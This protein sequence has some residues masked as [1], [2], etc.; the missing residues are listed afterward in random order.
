[1]IGE[2]EE[3]KLSPSLS[4]DMWDR[5]LKRTGF[6]GVETEVHDCESEEFY[7]FSVIKSTASSSTP[8]NYDSEIVL[9]TG[10]TS[11]S[12]SWL[13]EL[14]GSI[15][16]AIGITPKIESLETVD[17]E[18]KVCIFLGDLQQKSS[19]RDPNFTEFEAIKSLCTKSKGLLWATCGGAVDCQNPDASLS[20]GFLRT[21]RVEYAGKRMIALDLDPK[22]EFWSSRTVSALT[23]VVEKLF[24][25]SKDN[26]IMDFELADRDGVI[27]VPRYY[28]DTERNKV[29]FADPA[30]QAMVQL[31]PFCQ[32]DRPF[33]LTVGTPGLLDTLAFNDDPDASKELRHDSVEIEPQAFGVNFRDVMVA[34][35][36]LDADYMGFECSGIVKRVG[37][38]AAAEGLK[39][40]DRVAALM[41][42]HYGNL[43]RV[44]WTSAVH[45]PDDMTFEIAATLPMCY[46]TAYFS[47]HHLGR[48]QKGD[49]VLIHAGT[50]GV[51]QAAIVLAKHAGA[52]IFVTVGTEKK[53]EFVMN[54]YG[55]QPDHIFSSRDASFAPGV[56]AMTQGKGV[57]IVLNTLAGPLLQ[58][59]FNCIARFGRF[60]EIGKRDLEL[61]SSL[62][63]GAFTRSVSF[64]SFDLLL[65]GEYQGAEV[66]RVLKEIIHLFRQNIITPVQPV[67]IFPLSDIEKTFRL[68]QAGK[69]M[70]KIVVSVKPDDLVPVSESNFNSQFEILG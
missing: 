47:L 34:M 65:F 55:I 42:G 48:V 6:G 8:S 32:D 29:V 24:D 58:E 22:S 1:L 36:Q 4:I 31:E 25:Y 70:G 26:V 19:L 16:K 56:L 43:V 37:S 20:Q 7:S 54:E 17:A 14:K 23:E 41:R 35:G 2:E 67:T 49:K 45:I 5:V 11:P 3:R 40:G 30:S 28:R 69:H 10:T 66:N 57:E 27:Q 59:S 53:R 62:E 52:E 63:M 13:E 68:M 44:D 15:S 51:G 9:I 33:R 64:S 39:V 60:I 61:N 18:G 38:T 46:T 21:L 50:G 12:T